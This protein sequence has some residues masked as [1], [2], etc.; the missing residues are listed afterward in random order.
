MH[1]YV[2]YHGTTMTKQMEN[3]RKLHNFFL[4]VNL[5]CNMSYLPQ[6]NFRTLRKIQLLIGLKRLFLGTNDPPLSPLTWLPK[7]YN[8]Q[9]VIYI[10]NIGT[11]SL[12]LVS[13]CG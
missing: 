13:I 1:F 6:H 3:Q 12:S 7:P 11:K 10:S 2:I 4:L 5:N 8:D 9:H